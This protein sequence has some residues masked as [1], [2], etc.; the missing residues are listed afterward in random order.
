VNEALAQLAQDLKEFRWDGVRLLITS[1]KVDKRKTFYKTLEKL[2]TVETFAGWSLD[3]KDWADQAEIAARKQLRA[4]GKEISEEALAALVANIGPN[5]RLLNNEVEKLALY[6]GDRANITLVD[7]ETIVTRN[8]QAKAFALA[9]ALGA[10]SLAR[11]LKTLD[12]ELWTMQTDPNR[13]EIG[14]LYGI[15]SK[16][17]AM[18]FC[19]EMAREGWLKPDF[20]FQRFK[21]ALERIPAEALPQDRKFN[22]LAIHPWM[23]YNALGQSKNYTS[24]E[25]V[26]AMELLLQCNLRLISSSLD[27]ALALQET[28]IRIVQS[29]PG[30][31]V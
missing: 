14:V 4:L 17:R 26:R 23:L 19:K 29:A 7:I 28:L 30:A 12:H 20:E 21:A 11:L 18:L 2:G 15:I 1:G 5:N 3:D 13:N 10:R 25:L 22:P 24:E 8:K 9:D 27:P 31:R 6:C 16:V